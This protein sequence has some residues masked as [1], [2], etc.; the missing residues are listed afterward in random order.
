MYKY[1]IYKIKCK[2]SKI[3]LITVIFNYYN[4]Y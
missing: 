2:K 1:Y 3:T 4:N